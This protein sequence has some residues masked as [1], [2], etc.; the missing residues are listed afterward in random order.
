MRQIGKNEFSVISAKG[1]RN[2][3]WRKLQI[4]HG[5][6][7]KFLDKQPPWYSIFNESKQN[8]SDS[9]ATAILELRAR[10][11]TLIHSNLVHSVCG[12]S[13]IERRLFLKSKMWMV[14]EMSHT[15]YTVTLF[16]SG[17]FI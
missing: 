2:S 4:L 1:S 11:S 8:R 13:W 15:P 10:G 14:S 17:A 16:W 12:G 6:E 7:S 3:K 9:I 5:E